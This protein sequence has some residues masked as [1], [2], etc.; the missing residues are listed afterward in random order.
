MGTECSQ[1]SLPSSDTSEAFRGLDPGR[2]YL[3]SEDRRYGDGK[4]HGL[5]L[6]WHQCRGVAHTRRLHGRSA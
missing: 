6:H 2:A 1:E 3:V 4:H 5:V